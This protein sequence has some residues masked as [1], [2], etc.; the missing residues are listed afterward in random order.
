MFTAGRALSVLSR[1]NCR[2][3]TRRLATDTAA[4]SA[5]TESSRINL[6]TAVNDALQIAVED[7]KRCH[8]S[9]CN[10]C[11]IRLPCELEVLCICRCLVFGEDVSFGGVFRC[12]AGL[13]QRFGKERVFNTPL[14]EQVRRP[15][16][17]A[18]LCGI[19]HLRPNTRTVAMC[20]RALLG[21]ELEQL[22]LV[23]QQ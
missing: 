2:I 15:I 13:L 8:W 7:N 12:T 4:A 23:I 1:H 21:L 18:L 5:S 10:T 11:S 20:H 16:L 3:A 17:T 9:W 22:H 6:C 19:L 14:S